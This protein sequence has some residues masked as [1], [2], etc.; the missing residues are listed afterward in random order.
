MFDFMIL[1]YSFK[2][3]CNQVGSGWKGL[4]AVRVASRRNWLSEVARDGGVGED[5]V[6]FGAHPI[7]SLTKLVD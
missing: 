5:G 6:G 4:T 1:C 2:R 7:P 3:N